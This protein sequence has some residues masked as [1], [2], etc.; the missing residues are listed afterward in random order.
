MSM[1]AMA[2]ENSPTGDRTLNRP[3]TPSGTGRVVY[4]FSSQML[5]IVPDLGSVMA[6][7]CSAW[8]SLPRRSMSRERMVM[9]WEAVSAVSPDFEMTLKSVRSSAGSFSMTKLSTEKR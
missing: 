8:R 4:P 5:R 6:T 7:I 3:P 1:P 9:N 2:A